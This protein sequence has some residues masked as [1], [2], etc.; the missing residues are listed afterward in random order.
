MPDP[1]QSIFSYNYHASKGPVDIKWFPGAKT[2]VSY[3]ALDRHI[4][5]G[6]GDQV[7]IIWEGNEPSDSSTLTYQVGGEW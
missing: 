5:E 1:N 2:N 3:N 4:N 7:A 6:R